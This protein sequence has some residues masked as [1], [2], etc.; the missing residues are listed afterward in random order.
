M[1]KKPKNIQVNLFGEQ[2]DFNRGLPITKMGYFQATKL[3]AAYCLA[4]YPLEASCKLCQNL[5]NKCYHNHNYYKCALFGCSSS[6]AS[7][8]RLS[9]VCRHFEG[10]DK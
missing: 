4:Q 1:G 8:I 3:H 10:R 9:Y 5:L 6:V 2:Q 7:D